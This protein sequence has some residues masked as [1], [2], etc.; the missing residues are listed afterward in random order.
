[1]PSSPVQQSPLS[2]PLSSSSL[3][4]L[5]SLFRDNHVGEIDRMIKKTREDRLNFL[6]LQDCAMEGNFRKMLTCTENVQIIN[7]KMQNLN[8]QIDP[9]KDIY[10][11]E[12]E[13][14]D[15]DDNSSSLME[16]EDVENQLYEIRGIIDDV[17][18]LKP[19]TTTYLPK[20]KEAKEFLFII[21][22]DIIKNP[23]CYSN[24]TLMFAINFFQ[25]EKYNFIENI[26]ERLQEAINDSLIMSNLISLYFNA[27]PSLRKENII[28]LPNILEIAL[29]LNNKE[30][31]SALS[32]S[33]LMEFISQTEKQVSKEYLFSLSKK[34]ISLSHNELPS[35]WTKEL[36]NHFKIVDGDGDGNLLFH[37]IFGC[38]CVRNNE[39]EDDKNN[40]KV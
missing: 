34:I 11:K 31:K 36:K 4:D 19:K 37:P 24:S 3:V 33:F 12:F 35:K 29:H 2:S 18:G 17:L 13:I 23:D 39:D 30:P 27:I 5:I 32:F 38:Q 25:K 1:M 22:K 26:N 6:H 9:F 16:Q 7:E 21:L 40:N 15:D 20:T 10:L 28:K 14:I 8:D